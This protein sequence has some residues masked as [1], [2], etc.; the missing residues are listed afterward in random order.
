MGDVESVK[1]SVSSFVFFLFHCFCPFPRFLS[2]E[3]GNTYNNNTSKKTTIYPPFCYNFFLSFQNLYSASTATKNKHLIIFI[4]L[5]L[6]PKNKS[7]HIINYVFY[8]IVL[9]NMLLIALCFFKT[10]RI[11][12]FYSLNFVD[13]TTLYKFDKFFIFY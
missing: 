5:K 9:R 13:Y 1:P 7:M 11:C 10:R 4:E 2:L 6:N 8:D 12:G 3:N